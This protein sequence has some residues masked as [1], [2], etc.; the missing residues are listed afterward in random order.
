MADILPPTDDQFTEAMSLADGCP[1]ACGNN[2]VPH[3]AEP[4]AGNSWTCHYRCSCGETWRTAW[5][6]S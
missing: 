2:A 1:T 5:K 6:V 4:A 3:H